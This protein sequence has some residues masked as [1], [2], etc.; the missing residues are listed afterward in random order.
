MNI[1]RGGQIAENIVE[2]TRQAVAVIGIGCR[3]P[4]AIHD[5][6][7][8]WN[9]L[10]EKKC[11]IVDIPADRWNIDAF[12]DADPDAP[13]K[14]RSRWG[15]FLGNDVF[16]FDPSF[17]DMSPREV[18]SMDPQQRLA[19]QVAYEAVQDADRTLADLQRVRTGVFIGISTNDFAQNL[20]RGRT[21]GGDIFAG[22]GSAF[23]IAANRISHRFNLRGPSIAVDTACSSALVA[24]D[25]AVRH[26]SMGTC[27]M[28]LAGG[29]NCMLDPG[30]FVAFSSANMLSPTGG[31]YTF[32]ERADGFIRGEGC[33]LVLLK[34][35]DRAI[36]DGDRIYG[37]IRHSMVNQDGYTPTLTAPSGVAQQAMLEALMDGA[38]V[39]PSDVD[40]VE[41][42]GTGTPIGD[43]IEATAIGRVFGTSSRPGPIHVGSFKP[44]LGHL[45][46]ASGIAGFIKTL[47]TVGHGVVLPNRNFERPNPNI[48][49][50]AL[51]MTV[52]TKPVPID[53]RGRPVLAVVNSFGFGG[54]NASIVVEEWQGRAAAAVRMPRSAEVG[55]PI[56]LPVSA[57][58][59]AALELWAGSLADALE[60]GGSLQDTSVE[61]LA[62]HMRSARDN[63]AQRAALVVEPERSAVQ[64]QLRALAKGSLDQNATGPT[65]IT[66]RASNR[67]LAVAFSGQGGQWWA[68]ARR[69]LK[70][71][72]AFRRT[73]DMFDEVLRPMVGWSTVEEMLRD[74]TKTRINDA[75]VTQASIFATQISLYERWKKMGVRPELLIG[76]SFGEVAATYVSG[77]IDIETAARIIATRGLIPLKSTRRGAMATIGLTVQQLAPF[78]P[79]DDSVVIA[80]YNGP[81]AQTISGME[82]GVVEVLAK[83]AEAYP[84]AM[85]RRMTMDFGW[86]SAHL[87]DCKEWFLGELGPVAW[88]GGS[89]PIV[90]TVTGIFETKFDAAYWWD[91]LR[92]PVSFTKALDFTLDFGI[93]T[94]LEVGPHRT[95][96]PLIRGISQERGAD[97]VA[98]NSLDRTADDFW[99]LA[100]AE[101]RLYVSG[102]EF[103][104]PKAPG[105]HVAA[106][107]LPWNNQHLLSLSEETK[108]FLFDAP[109]HPLLGRRDFTAGPSWTNEISLRGFKYLAD[110]RVSG[111]CLFPAV[112]YIEAMGAALR[113]YFGS[114]SV[115]LRDFKLYEAL[116]IAEDDVIIFTTTFDPVGS[117]LRISTL[118]RGSEDGWRTRAEAYGFSHKYDLAPASDD[119]LHDWP[120][121]TDKTEFYRLAER[122]GLEYGPTFQSLNAL[123]IDGH[124]LIARLS[125]RE[126]EPAKHYFAFPGLLDAVLQAGIGLASHLDG[127][128]TPGEPLPPANEDKTQYQLR[129]PTGARK[130]QL[131]AP[132]TAEVIVGIQPGLDQD[133][134]QFSVFSPEG[135]PLIV[136][137][138][139]Q[140]KALGKIGGGRT[141]HAAGSGASVF[142]EHFQK[143]EP[144]PPAPSVRCAHWLVVGD[145]TQRLEA[146]LA[147]LVR[148]G[149]TVEIADAAPFLT[150]DTDEAL[151]IVRAFT[152]KSE[153]S[154][155]ILFSAAAGGTPTEGTGGEELMAAITP[156]V[157]QLI[158]LAKVFDRLQ[159]LPDP[160][161]ELVVVT[162]GSRVVEGD[163]P[164]SLSG[165]GESA[166]IGVAR[167]I[168]NEC[169]GLSLR[170]VD[171]DGAA[172]QSGSS[173]SDAV[174]E[175]TAET[176]F[177]LRGADR[178]VPR[179]ERLALQELAPSRRT[180]ETRRDPSNFA[181]TMTAPGTI[182]NI[183]LREI[184]DPVL[185]ADEVMVEVAAVGLNFR[186]IMAATSILPDEL[187]NDEAYWRNL[188]L[189]FAGT[190]REVGHEVTDLKPGDRIMGIGKGYLRRFAKIGADVV[191][192]VPDGIDLID[193]ATL[194]T[195]F[196]TAHYALTHV[197]RL[198]EDETA[199]I[200]LA[201]GG[202]GLA[203]IQVAR[204]VGA[205]VFGTAG[206]DA[207][208]A[209]LKTLGVDVAMNSRALDFADEVRA[210]TRGHGVD[211]V[212]NALSGHGI[213]KSLECLAPFG[214]MVEIGKRDL[215]DD[216]PIGLRSLY[217]NNAYSVIDL[218]TLP[219]ERPKLFRQLLA[220]VAGKVA[221]GAYKPLEATRF[222]A[223][224]AAEAM[225][226]LSRAQHIGKVIVTFDEPSLDIELDLG[227]DFAVSAEASYLVTGGLKG[228]GV[229]IADWLSQSGA[230]TLILAN[231]SGEPDAQAAVAIEA[232]EQ[233]GTRVVRAALDVTDAAAVDRLVAEHG[234]GMHPLRGIVHGAAVIEDAFVSQLDADKIDRVLRPKIAGGWNLH[235]AVVAHGIPLEFFVNFSSI[236]QVIGSSGQA[237]YTAANSVLNA[238]ATYRR[239]R[240]MAASSIAW[241]MIA[242]SGFVARSEAM[243]NYLDSVGIKP[244]QDSEAAAALAILLRARSENLG[245]ANID[246]AAI[247]RTNPGAAAN[248]RISQ[249]LGERSGGRSRIQAELAAA[250]REA[251]NDLLAD[252]IRREVAKVLKVEASALAD[253]RKL[254]ELGLDSLS[255]FELKNRVEAQVEVD[256]PVAKFLQSPTIAGLSRLVASAFEAKLK[257]AAVQASAARTS[258]AGGVAQESFR[259]LGRQVHAIMLDTRPMSSAVAMADNQVFGET[260][261]APGTSLAALAARLA[262][263]VASND[264]LR[265]TGAV[266]ASG[267]VEIGFDGDPALEV[268]LPGTRLAMVTLPGPL[269]R[270]GLC[271]R[272]DGSHDLQVRAH[273]AAADALSVHL[274]LAGLAREDEDAV[275]TGGGFGAY[276]RGAYPEPGSAEHRRDL[277]YWKEILH[278]APAIAPIPGRRRAAS[279]TG[280]GS[281]RGDIAIMQSIIPAAS[282]AGTP[283]LSS[284]RFLAAYAKALAGRFALGSIVVDKWFTERG[285]GAPA[286]LIG[287]LDG[288]YPIVLRAV[289]QAGEDLV[290]RIG[291]ADANGRA[292]RAVD[293]SS[294]EQAFEESL[295]IRHVALRQ[296][297]F[298]FI[299]SGEITAPGTPDD[300][301]DAVAVSAH[302]IQLAVAVDDAGVL[303]RLAVDSD[304]VTE[305]TAQLLFEDF[306]GELA[307]LLETPGPLVP[308]SVRWT[309]REWSGQQPAGAEVERSPLDGLPN[310]E[311]EIPVTSTQLGVLYL[312]DHPDANA[313]ALGTGLVSKE[314]KIRPQMDVDRLR[315][316]LETVMARHEV[317]RTRFFRKAGGYGAY[318][319]RAPTQFLK[320]EEVADEAAALE[321]ASELAQEHIDIDA[322]MFRTTVIR[323]GTESDIIV[324]KAHHLVIDGYSLGLIVEE[325]VKAYLGLP[326]NPVEMD[327][328]RFIRDFDHVGKPGSFERREEFL[329]KVFAE[330][331]PP[332]PNLGRKAKGLPTNVNFFDG[333]A[334]GLLTITIPTDE[335]DE[336]RRRARIAGTTE[337]AMIIAAF[338]QT[339]G[340]RGGVDDMI[341]QVPAALRHDRRLENYVNFVAS[342]VPVRAYLAR[343]DTIEALAVSLGE[344]VDEAIQ[345]GPFMDSNFVGAFH[346]DVVAKGSY[347]ALFL[348]GNQTVERWTQA[349]QSAPLQRAHASG[350][351]DLGMV[352]VTPLPD[353][354]RERPTLYELDVRTYP[355]E[356]G[357]GLFFIY[358]TRGY[359]EAEARDILHEIVERLLAGQS[360]ADADEQAAV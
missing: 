293:T 13:G 76:H 85:A 253:D 130:I 6:E 163:G 305:A 242:G 307:G 310:V 217:R 311:R 355:T 284:E 169:K 166:L 180:L 162:S 77:I 324:A 203:A 185:A 160:R 32:D 281:N 224:R 26:M 282:F 259:P 108:S 152:A 71:D 116:S 300:P 106:P 194:P 241:G 277:S 99:T 161:P 117:R 344:G 135:K 138:N 79:G 220:E 91:N 101:G 304:V 3:F 334:G 31:I 283:G 118:H 123:H 95:L 348:A 328:D 53:H 157:H 107:K 254:S 165:L 1:H 93:N 59:T 156:V 134:M 56:A 23:S 62:T 349:T 104:R 176:E 184:A 204:D 105:G 111:D 319:E 44:N 199:L 354:R 144:K 271:A 212:L 279:P 351:L 192:R 295:R 43:P 265:M 247:A 81:I 126:P 343:F 84:D 61:D 113:E 75:D 183:V 236:A 341:L 195:A 301:L 125:S 331:L 143:Q 33:G 229:A 218:S 128:W 164:M 149:A 243:T 30:P 298:A 211:V 5:A 339:V 16:G 358:D 187:E 196:L 274:L 221:S 264:A 2:S 205:K 120:S 329:H 201:S 4:G 47:L 155:G 219:V 89:L 17:F 21:S 39:D 223:S 336:L 327:I 35:L 112:G 273:R 255:S 154:G 340:A 269:W 78:L 14:M 136:I 151:A 64:A 308:G 346:D 11:G 46:S 285:N 58:S 127:S 290:R 291:R 313:Y 210:L 50:D 181:V 82:N 231:R 109:R 213:D 347:T 48:P 52:A 235:A 318:L 146:T 70:E 153:Q 198:A 289:D 36:A 332:I 12:Y 350:E 323:F 272:Q 186:D 60:D 250:P 278:H 10:L 90:S 359:D 145:G 268:L 131:G 173:V 275:E 73:A 230:G 137:D 141:K 191:M 172:L 8:Y 345:F 121:L 233:R 208:R 170:L 24:L 37:V 292:H 115:E 179:L 41:A 171:A 182:D 222:P 139:L 249:L 45:E 325:T 360:K 280:M 175:D 140:T 68:M 193:A 18:T 321:R 92:Q 303:C 338:A 287:P 133:S 267:A 190:V 214:R 158:T 150:L 317:M 322:P 110:H 57:G 263:L 245:F 286:G 167:T 178:Y 315:R 337:T 100:R 132:L 302:E 124:R 142:E 38:S 244:V 216:K 299:G 54:T 97:V 67:R 316:A 294:L 88:K 49:F 258:A 232:M 66:G 226:M 7:S 98:A 239:G 257:A 207:K 129:L 270:V 94:F 353:M 15:G 262:R 72:A 240:S 206:S 288:S 96:T 326:L 148:R 168:A 119:I 63:F 202:V 335:R 248:P 65:I 320:V 27:D 200:H 86:H 29:V 34:L 237:N 251:W 9:F 22:T 314:F 20:R 197:G 260:N 228:F 189:E 69:L 188:G 312:Q 352:K 227:S 234:G 159:A 333:S 252:M 276:V 266:S 174:L 297:G 102:V 147:E 55:H 40:Y 342:D 28:A 356:N 74:E 296:F 215:A 225:R 246:W 51:N 42:H 83:V 87:E 357:L 19:L 261:V 114:E 177:V 122:H 238:I 25:Q 330:P 209:F 309:V 103:E 256:I 306:L 80:A